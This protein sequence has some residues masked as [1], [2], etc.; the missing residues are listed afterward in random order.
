MH[1]N[2]ISQLLDYGAKLLLRRCNDDEAVCPD[3][4]MYNAVDVRRYGPETLERPT[5]EQWLR[6][7]TDENVE[8]I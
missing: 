7:R 8:F 3:E 6:Y 4:V 1:I 5:L 2:S